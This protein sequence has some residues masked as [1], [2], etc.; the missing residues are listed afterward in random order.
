M[1]IGHNDRIAWGVTN[2]SVDTQD[3]FIE[4]INPDDPRQ[5]EYQ[6]EWVDAERRPETIVVAGGDDVDYEVLVTRHGPIISDTY[7]DDPPF[8]GSDTRTARRSTRC[9]SPGRPFSHRPWSRPI[10]GINKAGDYEEFRAAASKWD[11]AAQNL[12]YAD[13]EGNIAY[14]ST[15]EV[16]I[17]ADR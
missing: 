8:Q 13:V 2:E 4:K 9:P 14:Q 11:I 3:L 15:G 1:V 17:R 5:Y 6:G 16:P 12:V 7:F 10:I